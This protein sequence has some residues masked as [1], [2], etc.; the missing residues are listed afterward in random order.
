MK[1]V[2]TDIVQYL[3]EQLQ[4]GQDYGPDSDSWRKALD[5]YHGRP[6]G[7]EVAGQPSVQSLDVAD[8]I[9]A[10]Q[11][12][13]LPTF[14][15][16]A[17]CSFEPDGQD[18]EAQARLESDATNRVMMETNRGYIVL[19]TALKNALQLKNGI[20]K[21]WLDESEET[22]S[23]S[24]GTVTKEQANYIQNSTGP[25]ET[26]TVTEPDLDDFHVR[27]TTT[28]RRVR[29]DAVDPLNFVVGAYTDGILLADANFV[30]ERKLLTRADLYGMG[31]SMTQVDAVAA[32]GASSTT[33]AGIRFRD[34]S[35]PAASSM[36]SSSDEVELWEIYA[37]FDDGR[38]YRLQRCMVAG[39]ELLD[40]ED[41]D[42]IPYAAGSA[43]LE[44]HRFWGLSVY[45][46]LKSVQDSKTL[47]LRQWLANLLAGNLNRTAVNDN[48]NLEDMTS[49]RSSGV[50]K[51]RTSGPVGENLMPFP[52][53]DTGAS[54]AAM[55]GYMDQ[56][57]G[58]RAGAAL[59]MA[60][61][62]M[63]TGASAIGSQGIDRI[64]SVQEQ[65][66]GWIARTMAETLLRSSFEL[67]H[68]VLRLEYAKP[69]MLQLADQ[70]VETDPRTWRS[71]DRINIKAGLSAGERARK[72]AAMLNVIQLQA[73]NLQMGADGVLVDLPNLYAAQLDWAAAAEI[74]GA[75]RYWVDPRGQAAQ[76]AQVEK[77]RQQAQQAQQAQQMQQMQ[78][79]LA[80]AQL[81]I[82]ALKVEVTKANNDADT[83]FKYDNARLNAEIEEA[84]LVGQVT[85]DL[86]AAQRDATNQARSTGTGPGTDNPGG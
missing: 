43:W 70:W 32:Y 30:A 77:G 27:R 67:V 47:T 55:L 24:F 82:E 74:D 76:A 19:Y 38:G 44:S 12:Q 14:A 54:S 1:M 45:D 17:L 79:Q 41:A 51:V 20:V 33:D 37:R 23:Q 61:A 25:D 58:D 72:A 85:A 31:Y 62:E 40:R 2:T 16:D 48:V 68:R 78:V 21:V 3:Q 29:M 28:R 13:I 10:I 11:A 80:Q 8:M 34:G 56:V 50:I 86:T 69:L 83:R 15:G 73:Q 81:Q 35:L 5:Y 63:Q 59:Q 84:K 46:R 7:D 26:L 66:A 53:V 49:G 71:R 18:D 57:R 22:V 64:Y 6:R 4:R 42:Y 9:H 52:F 75:Q 65:L 39:Q 60:S 36:A